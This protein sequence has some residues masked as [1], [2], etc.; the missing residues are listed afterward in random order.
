[1]RIAIFHNLPSGGAKRALY[2][3]T[4]RLARQH[5]I[6]IF[7]LS[8]ADHEFCDLRQFVDNYCILEFATR[9]LFG[10][11]MGRLNQ[12]QR[13]KDLRTLEQLGSQLAKEINHGGYDLLFANPCK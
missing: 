8:T 9:R 6:D 12:I 1:M 7:T 4:R 3:W 13:W 11:P 10:S 5:T 2:E